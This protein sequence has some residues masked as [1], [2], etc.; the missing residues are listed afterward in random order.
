MKPGRLLILPP[1]VAV[2]ILVALTGCTSTRPDQGDD[3]DSPKTVDF[4]SEVKPILE[5]QCV[6][7]HNRKA[8]PERHSFETRKRLMQGDD[9]GPIIIPGDPD[10]SRL[11]IAISSPDFHE[12]AMP[13]I[14]SRITSVEIEKL[15]QWI[16][17]GADWPSGRAGHLIPATFP[18]E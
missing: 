9:T 1:L 15:K 8:L 14:G 12:K 4:L 6:I 5:K 3:E 18:L 10:A 13:P 16:R 17:E 2:S 11:I 7:C